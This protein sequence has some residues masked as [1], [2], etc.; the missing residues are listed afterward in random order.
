MEHANGTATTNGHADRLPNLTI[1]DA[2]FQELRRYVVAATDQV[3][4]HSFLTRD[5]LN[6]ALFDAR[7]DVYHECGYVR[8][9]TLEQYLE[10]YER[11]DYAKTVVELYPSECWQAPP[12]VYEEEEGDT[13]TP[14]EEAWDNLGRQLRG[15][16]SWYG[17]EADNPV[18]HYLQRIDKESG[19]GRYGLLLIGID[20]GLPLDAPVQGINDLGMSKDQKTEGAEAGQMPLFDRLGTDRQYWDFYGQQ[21]RQDDQQGKNGN[22]KPANGQPKESKRR[23]LTYLRTFAEHLCP[24]VQS[25]QRDCPR[26]GQPYMYNVTMN[27][28]RGNVGGGSIVSSQATKAVHWTRV[29]HVADVHHQV[30]YND[31]MARPRLQP[32]INPLWDLLKIGGSAS[33]GFWQAC[34][35]IIAY[36]THPQLGADV[37]VPTDIK[38]TFENLMFGLKRWVA[39]AGGSFKTLPPQVSDP[40]GHIT[41]RIKAIATA[42]RC[43]VRIFEGS[44]RGELASSQDDAAWND[45]VKERQKN[46]CT[47][48]IIIPFVDRLI[49]M[50]VLPKPANPRQMVQKTPK[51]K[52]AAPQQAGPGGKPGG[53]PGAGG[54]PKPPG[55]GAPPGAPKPPGKS[56][57]FTA[58]AA[59]P[60]QRVQRLDPAASE[61]E[62]DERRQGPSGAEGEAPDEA[63]QAGGEGADALGRAGPEG[64]DAAGE[65]V[66]DPLAGE[67]GPDELGDAAQLDQ[68]LGLDAQA[69][70]DGKPVTLG[71][72][73]VEWPDLTSMSASEKATVFAQRIGAYASAIS[74]D[75]QQIIPPLVMMTE[76][77]GMDEDKAISYLQDAEASQLEQEATEQREAEEQAAMNP[78]MQPAV[79]EEGNPL[80]PDQQP[81]PGMPPNGQ[82]PQA[83]PGAPSAGKPGQF[84]GPPRPGQPPQTGGPPPQM[85]KK[86]PP[87]GNR[88]LDDILTNADGLIENDCG[89]GAGGFASGN[90]CAKGGGSDL[91]EAEGKAEL[92]SKEKAAGDASKEKAESQKSAYQR[93]SEDPK[94]QIGYVAREQLGEVGRELGDLAGKIAGAPVELA[95]AYLKE[96]EIRV[97]DNEIKRAYRAIG[98]DQYEDAKGIVKGIFSRLTLGMGPLGIKAIGY[99]IKYGPPAFK[100]MVKA[101]QGL[102]RATGWAAKKLARG[103]RQTAA[104]ATGGYSASGTPLA[105]AVNYATISL[106]ELLTRNANPEG[107][108]QHTGPGCASGPK[109]LTVGGGHS[110]KLV[111]GTTQKS[112]K[113]FIAGTD[114]PEG[115]RSKTY[116][117][118]GDGVIYASDPEAPHQAVM[119]GSH[120]STGAGGKRLLVEF[121]LRD[122]SKV[123]DLSDEVTR[124]PA[125]ALGGGKEIVDFKGRPSV[126]DDMI[127]WLKEKRAREGHTRE[128]NYHSYMDPTH[129]DFSPHEY[130]TLLKSYA[131][132]RGYA[133]VRTHDE[134]VI[135]DRSAIESARKI[136]KADEERLRQTPRARKPYAGGNLYSEFD[137]VTN[138]WVSLTRNAFPREDDDETTEQA[139]PPNHQA[140]GEGSQ[141][142]AGAVPAAAGPDAAPGIDAGGDSQPDA[143]AGADDAEGAGA[144][145]EPDDGGPGTAGEPVAQHLAL[146]KRAL[147]R[148]SAN[149]QEAKDF[150]K[151]AQRVAQIIAASEGDVDLD[152]EPPDEDDPNDPTG[153][154][155][156]E[157]EGPGQPGGQGGG[158]AGEEA[159][160]GQ[161]PDNAEGSNAE[162]SEAG[163]PQLD[164]Y[165]PLERQLE[166]EEVTDNADGGWV[167]LDGGQRVF[168]GEGGVQPKGPGTKP[169]ET[170]QSGKGRASGN[171]KPFE[172][173]KRHAD[174]HPSPSPSEARP[175]ASLKKDGKGGTVKEP[176]GA[177]VPKTL[178]EGEQKQSAREPEAKPPDDPNSPYWRDQA[179]KEAQGFYSAAK[180]K[181]AAWGEDFYR[182]LTNSTAD[183]GLGPV[184]GG[185]AQKLI[186]GAMWIDRQLGKGYDAGQRLSHAVAKER[187]Y[188]D[189]T[190]N[191]AARMLSV[192][193]GVGRWGANWRVP[194]TF[195][196]AIGGPVGLAAAGVGAKVSFY[197]PAASLAFVGYQMGRHA[198]EGKNPFSMIS[199]ARRKAKAWKAKGQT[200]NASETAHT[201][202]KGWAE[203]VMDWM[204]QVD[205]ADEA[206]AC[207]AAALDE[208]RG[209]K[210]EALEMAK[211]VCG[212]VTENSNPEGCNQYTGPDCAG[213]ETYTRADG[214][215]PK[216]LVE[217]RP[218]LYGKKQYDLTSPNGAPVRGLPMSPDDPRIPD[219]IYHMTGNLPAVESSGYLRASG[220]GG[221]GGDDRDQ[222]VSMTLDKKVAHDLANDIRWSATTM[223]KHDD[224]PKRAWDDKQEKWVGDRSDWAKSVME[225]FARKAKEDGWEGYRPIPLQLESYGL[226]DHLQ[227][228]YTLRETKT[229]QKNPLF[230]DQKALKNI[231]PSKVGVVEIPKAALKTGAMLTDFDLDNRYGLKEVRMYGDVPLT[232][233]PT[234]NVFCPTGIGGG[235]D[236]TC[237]PGEAGG[238]GEKRVGTGEAVKREILSAAAR[239]AFSDETRD[240]H[241]SEVSEDDY[242]AIEQ[243][244]ETGERE[245]MD[246]RLAEMQDE[247]RDAYL[248]DF[249][250]DV[251]RREV[252]REAGWSG[253]DIAEKV[254]EM[255]EEADLEDGD[256]LIK[257]VDDL[258]TVNSGSRG[259]RD[260]H[261]ALSKYEPPEDE[262][263]EQTEART[264]LLRSIYGG[265]DDLYDKVETEV[266]EAVEA[267]E[268][269]QRESA[270]ESFEYHDSNSDRRDYL[271]QFYRDNEERFNASAGDLEPMTWYKSSGS[272]SS[273]SRLVFET[274]AGTPYAIE[275]TPMS[276]GSMA[277]RGVRAH[278]FVFTQENVQ[279][280]ESVGITGAGSASEVFSNVMAAS[281][282]YVKE[283][284]PDAVTF[285]AAE[286]S[287]QKLYDRVVK[288]LAKVADGYVALSVNPIATAENPNAGY[289]QYVVVKRENKDAAIELI[290]QRTG[291][292]PKVLVNKDAR[293]EVRELRPFVS[294]WWNAS[295]VA[296]NCGIGS[297]GFEPGNTCA[298][299]GG[300]GKSVEDTTGLNVDVSPGSGSR[301]SKV[302]PVY[303]TR[304]EV[305]EAFGKAE[306]GFLKKISQEERD[307]LREYSEDNSINEPLR[308]GTLVEG[309]AAKELVR[310]RDLV[311]AAIAK[312]SFPKAASVSRWVI[313]PEDSDLKSLVG[314]AIAD[315]AYL[316]TSLEHNRYRENITDYADQVGEYMGGAAAVK[317]NIRIPKG[318]KAAMLGGME[319]ASSS[320]EVL[321]PR[322]AKL[323]VRSVYEITNENI[324]V[325]GRKTYAVDVDY[326]SN[327]VVVNQWVIFNDG[328][329][330]GTGA[331][332]FQGGNDC[333]AEGG[334][335]A[336]ITSGPLAGAK[337]TQLGKKAHVHVAT[338]G[339]RKYVVKQSRGNDADL[340]NEVMI[341]KMAK[342][343][344]VN[345]PEAQL[346][347]AGGKRA[348]ATDMVPGETLHSADFKSIPKDQVE[349]QLA[350]DLLTGARDRH[351]GQYLFDGKTL[352]AIDNELTFTPSGRGIGDALRDSALYRNLGP[353]H[354]PDRGILK[355]M[356]DK[357][358]AVAKLAP[359][360]AQ[361][362]ILHRGKL[363]AQAADGSMSLNQL[364]VHMSK[365]RG[366]LG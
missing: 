365:A 282:A 232:K 40:T 87:V 176:T 46:Y 183:G 190:A 240:P 356:A 196:L 239:V 5:A 201:S 361:A 34:F 252:A 314:K 74:G 195:G 151:V 146:L 192:A 67:G 85:F 245:E 354:R 120:R 332:G 211:A 131:K 112:A 150:L 242:D 231:D 169:V 128:I 110:G 77:D 347:E 194:E 92:T 56:N 312:S 78:I 216:V 301:P 174:L 39:A 167:T 315:K 199:R 352:S 137:P 256:A 360:S 136:G 222:I 311:D 345:V 304:D 37:D 43:P 362:D 319:D 260:V 364:A 114:L 51:L 16:Q 113:H 327:S 297:E 68:D 341:S 139:G 129:P 83:P 191:R 125:V 208:T 342:A 200:R 154:M 303:T 141:A 101:G 323:Q 178:K 116:S 134:T 186:D 27:D 140:P 225:D 119:F 337:L 33:E 179:P 61:D 96:I 31:W 93:A 91:D 94:N 3:L 28:P 7:R 105:P 321:L 153:G 166:D 269:R 21:S 82:A 41:G 295:L 206:E 50:G 235:V 13:I 164:A 17:E 109:V 209:D 254:K 271:R 326:V 122:G 81:P 262:D 204:E 48:R 322:N 168:V 329:D 71:G 8:S 171:K 316:S 255:I 294:H 185:A 161:Q 253:D 306:Q 2:Q 187:G 286:P 220:E 339:D 26:F 130:L 257:L 207:L 148:L 65:E 32:V 12:S 309:D 89:T 324:K 49:A 357:A 189:E 182:S 358:R 285:S 283:H 224:P 349:R 203:A 233:S 70:Q 104:D 158:A 279:G 184:V 234:D 149:P 340:D 86:K 272:S 45:R 214:S 241:H 60:F 157:G 147:Q 202:L 53:P 335:T 296:N 159:V 4:N 20:D 251:D 350:F 287:R 160:Q 237:S 293:W 258:E 268:N 10:A 69:P 52:L 331:G 226:S 300:G 299:G 142:P 210:T 291:K 162:I 246:E 305:E 355:G 133:A 73:K 24:I 328:S 80:P 249:E 107:C 181:M 102:G 1:N 317:F 121:K 274:K 318:A 313:V 123:L 54:P 108:N 18:W 307:A 99:G 25:E 117:E 343:A 284:D 276:G 223:Q 97:I 247:A 275:V 215:S 38:D 132:D 351:E 238:A 62:D 346:T 277:G 177:T 248:E 115:E 42:M 338:Q 330:C 266:N 292:D 126:T 218:S 363:L 333:A 198:L 79:D 30:G 278:D 298:K 72:Y 98:P 217:D 135:V 221:L 58:N 267:E 76:F 155:G 265:S 138:Q 111:H 348:V 84:G 64:G 353:G 334:G 270:S 344:G 259:A 95:R 336:S 44:E 359:K 88:S 35:S 261:A 212:G 205:D 9:P 23:K 57:P 228:Y 180:S 229:G 118:W 197:V 47:P 244:M 143:E 145:A 11:W 172:S 193:D 320:S 250:A 6:K 63:L 302:F 124:R 127:S 144:G 66:L 230:F 188:N 288:T 55:A 308:D 152:P 219:T 243:A 59:P 290:K 227:Q 289:R 75:V 15:E 100:M 281:V 103:V 163:E 29:L 165:V 366:W 22:G 156:D 273:D 90:E 213:G 173:G 175:T 19:L 106:D 310:Q 263:E 264:E 14:F 170:F 280:R 236:P 36:E 325:P